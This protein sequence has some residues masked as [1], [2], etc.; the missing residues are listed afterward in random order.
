[1][2][3]DALTATYKKGV[4]EVMVP[5]VEPTPAAKIAVKAG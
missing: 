2:E 1:M 5:K 4:L 3:P